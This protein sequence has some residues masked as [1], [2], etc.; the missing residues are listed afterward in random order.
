M[1][2][3]GSAGRIL[4]AML[5]AC[6]VFALFPATAFAKVLDEDATDGIQN[7]RLAINSKN[8]PDKNFRDYISDKFDSESSTITVTVNGQSTDFVFKADEGCANDG[9]LTSAELE[10]I[11]HIYCS[12]E[13]EPDETKKIKSLQGIKYFTNLAWL[14]CEY[15]GL[16]QTEMDFLKNDEVKAHWKNTLRG[17]QCAGNQIETLDLSEY[18]AFTTLGCVSK[19]NNTKLK[20]LKVNEGITHLYCYNNDLAELNVTDCTK[21]VELNCDNNP[22][23]QSL[24]VSN[25]KG[26]RWLFCANTGLTTLDVSKNEALETLRCDNN[27]LQ[28]LDVTNNKRLQILE[29][30]NTGLTTLD[31]KGLTKLEEVACSKNKLE[32]LYLKDKPNLVRVE[33]Q[34]NRLTTLD[35]GNANITKAWLPENNQYDIVADG[36]RQF[37]LANLP[38]GFDADKASNWSGGSEKDGVLTVDGTGS[39][40]TVTYEYD[41]G[42]GKS[43]VF[44]LNVTVHQHQY[45]ENDWHNDGTSHWHECEDKLCPNKGERLDEEKHTFDRDSQKCTVCQKQHKHTYD[46]DALSDW[47]SDGTN[48]WHECED[49]LCPNQGERLDEEKHDYN[50]A[51]GTCRVCGYAHEHDFTNGDTCSGCGYTR[52]HVH[53]YDEDVWTSDGTNH[54]HECI[55]ENCPNKAG[56]KKDEKPHVYDEHG[57]CECGRGHTHTYSD[58]KW[59]KDETGHWQ[60]CT[61]PNC[62]TLASSVQ[63]KTFHI[64]TDDKDTTC[65]VCGYVR[66]LTP[67]DPEKPDEPDD[68]PTVRPDTSNDVGGILA[69][70]IVGGTAAWGS[71][72]TATR[73][74][75]HSILPKGAEIPATRV[76]LAMLLWQ[77]AKTPEP[78]AQPAFADVA[79]P[80]QAKAAQWCV[81]QGLLDETSEG[82]FDP[83]GWMP[84]YKTI[85]VWNS[86]KEMG[87]LG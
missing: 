49:T 74:I 41:C 11:T 38:D 55:D 53:R 68:V 62:P 64:Y 5:A 37:K 39:T 17:L 34:Q 46:P 20:E 57:V 25:S 51:T 65:N 26:L 28:T 73:L 8:F 75:L 9:Y 33:A 19:G 42:S 72:E 31:L 4:V 10:R 67:D 84:K 43:A 61:D 44:T 58:T 15:N 59:E 32:K 6:A 7:G 63:N 60:Q 79:D 23:I 52:N 86:A 40:A 77:N 80:E 45:G 56:S 78:A 12:N 27:N 66:T 50:S 14:N 70:L 83:N 1:K 76:Q 85:K 71:Y 24:N 36:N 16:S 35:V 30:S 2:R 21:L 22:R 69:T 18:E 29:C 81:E 82:V 87:L 48:H 47:H 54:W 3:R 13:D